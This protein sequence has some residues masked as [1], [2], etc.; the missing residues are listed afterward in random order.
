VCSR[1]EPAP[2]PGRETEAAPEQARVVFGAAWPAV[3]RYVELLAGAGVER[4]LVGPHEPSRLW[5]RHVLNSAALAGLLAHG[6]EVLDL[7]SGAGLPGIPVALA[8][9]DLRLTLLEPMARRVAFLEEVVNELGLDVEV[10]RGRGE[11]VTP[12]STDA[13]IVRAVA[14]LARLV[15]MSL[16]ML[17]PGGR[18]LALK[19]STADAEIAAAKDVLRRWPLA[20]VSVVTVPAGAT[21]A[22]VVAIDMKDDVSPAK[23][24][25]R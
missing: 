13:V 25:E 8:R 9:P 10:R 19:G 22:T 2:D 12:S 16:P 20:T 1:G 11:D 24:R 18:L 6:S 21:T 14:P 7:G 3:T 23:D 5:S 17:R 4:G 15:P